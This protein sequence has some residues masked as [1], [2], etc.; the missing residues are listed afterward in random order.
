MKNVYDGTVVLDGSGR[1]TVELLDSC[2]C[3]AGLQRLTG[4]GADGHKGVLRLSTR[5]QSVQSVL[6]GL[7]VSESASHRNGRPHTRSSDT[8]GCVTQLPRA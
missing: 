1:A 8:P 3:Q 4:S 6:S 5:C 7:H 2:S